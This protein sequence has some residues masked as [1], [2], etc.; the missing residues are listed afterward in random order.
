M[1]D[2]TAWLKQETKPKSW[3][4]S[5]TTEGKPLYQT[6]QSATEPASAPAPHELLTAAMDKAGCS[7]EVTEHASHLP[8]SIIPIYTSK[9]Q[10]TVWPA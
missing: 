3:V 6:R 5:V 2:L 9:F 7:R 10:S 1:R 4:V 8:Y